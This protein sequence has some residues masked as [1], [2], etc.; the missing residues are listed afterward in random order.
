MA[1]LLGVNRCE[2]GKNQALSAANFRPCLWLPATPRNAL[3]IK[4]LREVFK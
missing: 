4:V 1:L 2:S 3:F